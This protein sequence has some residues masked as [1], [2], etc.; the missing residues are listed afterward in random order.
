MQGDNSFLYKLYLAKFTLHLITGMKSLLLAAAIFFGCIQFEKSQAQTRFHIGGITAVNTTF[1]LDKGLTNNPF[2]DPQRTYHWSPGGFVLGLELGKRKGFQLEPILA[3]QGQKFDIVDVNNKKIGERVI[4]L[5]YLNIPLMFKNSRGNGKIRWVTMYG[6]QLALLQEGIETYE[7]AKAT[8]RFIKDGKPPEG[9][10]DNGDGTYTIPAM[11]RTTI[12]S[13]NPD[14]IVA[15]FRDKDIQA[16]LSL[17]LEFDV[18]RYFFISTAIRGNYGFVDMRSG[19]LLDRLKD[20]TASVNDIFAR[21]A[22]LLAGVQVGL[23][24]MFGGVKSYKPKA[25]ATPAPAN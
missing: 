1:V 3:K 24:F 11:P 21:R 2:Y 10:V 12:A 25:G 17:G 8:V 14:S 23:H 16:I 19:E 5:Q 7:Y 4:E 6:A 22:N 20:G 15:A 18:S 9:S 13:T